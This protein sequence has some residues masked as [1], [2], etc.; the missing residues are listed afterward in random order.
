MRTIKHDNGF[1]E[2]RF[3]SYTDFIDDTKKQADRFKHDSLC[4][5]EIGH[6]S[7]EFRQT[8]NIAEAF[9]LADNGWSK[10]RKDV[11]LLVDKLEL[12]LQVRKPEFIFDV[13]G[14]YGFDMGKV[15][16]GEPENIISQIETDELISNANGP[17]VRMLV[18]CAISAGVSQ[19]IFTRRG[20]AIHALVD[21]L[22]ASGKRVELTT[23]W[24]CT[25]PNVTLWIPLKAADEALQTDQLAFALSHP[26]FVRR[27]CFVS[28]AQMDLRSAQSLCGF[29]A[30]IKNPEA[31][32]DIYIQK[33]HLDEAQWSSV[34]NMEK[35]ITDKLHSL[36]IKLEGENT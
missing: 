18:N 26:S 4:G 13:T 2:L 32:S 35:W 6:Y 7:F 23:I 3:D 21:L 20:A 22:E 1:I 25:S 27:L 15:M 29:P 28:H 17:I 19:D 16:S 14:D 11:K 24:H 9:K 5:L 36:G 8:N 30:D 34:A 10:G 12:D 31:I 33:M